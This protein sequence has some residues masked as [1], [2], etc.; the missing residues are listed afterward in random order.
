MFERRFEPNPN[1]AHRFPGA[2]LSRLVDDRPLYN[3]GESYGSVLSWEDLQQLGVEQEIAGLQLNYGTSRGDERLRTA[4]AASLGINPDQVLVTAGAIAALFLTIFT[5]VGPGDEVLTT[6][7]NFTPIFDAISAAEAV[8]VLIPLQFD[9][10]FELPLQPIEDLCSERTRL[11]IFTSP[12]TPSARYLSPSRL[13][14]AF[15][16]IRRKAPQARIIIDEDYRRASL[17]N[18]ADTSSVISWDEDVIVLESLSKSHGAP[19][20]RIGWLASRDT[21]FLNRVV[22]AKFGTSISAGVMDEALAR[23]ILSK[24]EQILARFRG[25][26]RQRLQFV[27]EWLSEEREWMEWL[28]PEAGAYCAVRLR[29]ERFNPAAVEAF[30]T[31]LD[32]VGVQL[33]RASWFKG[34]ANVMRLGFGHERPERL[35]E[36]L[37]IV[38]KTLKEAAASS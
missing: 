19:G 29:P 23:L 1:L 3:L 10:G 33:A 37:Q 36:A 27:E 6:A 14:D 24:E 20:L 31:N 35:A 16:I 25:E 21:N 12:G 26:L 4:L 8:P 34:P 38:T 32:S 30:F 28:Q 9:D 2:L 13:K 7:P 5:C 18:A 22:P 15:G 17:G 11:A